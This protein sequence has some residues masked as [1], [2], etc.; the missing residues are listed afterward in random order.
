MFL[1]NVNC[2]EKKAC[3]FKNDIKISNDVF[4]KTKDYEN[5]NDTKIKKC[6]TCEA[7]IIEND[8]NLKKVCAEKRC[9]LK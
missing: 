3:Q 8:K 2:G 7:R 6:A 9:R 1:K 4:E 5:D